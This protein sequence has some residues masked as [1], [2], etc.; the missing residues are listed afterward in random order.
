MICFSAS[1][2]T[3]LLRS[4]PATTRSSA[5]L[6][7]GVLMTFL[8]RRAA[9][10]AASLTRLARSA[11]EKPGDCLGDELE[12]DGLVERLALD[13]DLEDLQAAL[14]VRA[15][16]DDLAVEAAGAQERRVEHVG[17]VGG[18]DDDD[19]RVRVE[20]VHLDEDLV[21]R[22]LAL[23]VRA[24]EAGAALAADRVD[25]VH[26]DDAGAVALG[27]VEQV[28]HAAG[29]D[30]HEHL[31]ELGAR[32]AEEG[33]AGLAGDGAGEQRLAGARR[34][35]EQHAARDARPEGVELLGVLQELDDL[36]ELRLGLVHAGH[37]GEGDDRL[38]AQEHAGAALAE[39]H[40]LVV[41]ALRL[42]E[43]EE[44]DGADD[45]DGQGGRE[46]DAEQL[47]GTVRLGGADLHVRVA[48]RAGLGAD[49]RDVSQHALAELAG[50][51]AGDDPRLAGRGIVRR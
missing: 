41:G 47:A 15:V 17:A 16:E 51:L 40:R 44:E 30:A 6:N 25:L 13:V 22:L 12:V 3:R 38:V 8:L 23:V 49:G 32:D 34:P 35:D 11:P 36:L 2:M 18:G 45:D 28:A 26:E 20:A 1:L 43:H 21:E 37:V 10:M 24:A 29:A 14:H 19:V 48:G 46:Q 7:S 39:A 4:G 31:H 50:H 33:H 5:S 27:L 42:A 9:R